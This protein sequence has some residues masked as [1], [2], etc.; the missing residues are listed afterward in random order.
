MLENIQ[1]LILAGGISERFQTGKTKLLEK[2]C[3]IEMILYPVQLLKSIHVPTTIILSHQGQDIQKAIQKNY[4]HCSFIEQEKPLGTGH[5]VQISQLIWSQDHILIMHGNI[6]LVTADVINKLYRK[7]IKADADISFITAHVDYEQNNNARVI[8]DNQKIKISQN[9][10]TQIDSNYCC[11]SA[12]IFLAKR[13]F[14]EQYIQELTHD[15]KTGE[16]FLQEIVQIA[17]D[18]NCKIVTSQVNFDIVRSVETLADLWAVEHIK[19]S[20]I[21]Q[22]WMNHGVRFANTLNV[23]IDETVYIEPGVFIGTGV[24]LSGSTYIKQASSIGAYCQ[25]ENSTIE[26]DI[27]IP[28][29]V[30]I[31]NTTIT[32]HHVLEPFCQYVGQDISQKHSGII[33]IATKSK[34]ESLSSL[35]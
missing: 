4:T 12:G 15:E 25:I 32:H 24:I 2:I 30:M 9:D 14:L 35:S 13:T 23:L 28:S 29:Y 27:V 17:S 20:T 26:K 5:G 7:H 8:I 19:R 18:N 33:Y 1:A 21:L 34:D 6:P 16:I 31:R 22:Y 11:I 3:G 10:D